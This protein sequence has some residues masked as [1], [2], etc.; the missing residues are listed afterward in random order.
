MTFTDMPTLGNI[1]TTL[2]PGEGF[3]IHGAIESENEYSSG[4]I[5]NDP[6]KRP[7][8]SSVLDGRNNEQWENVRRQRNEKL[9]DS[10]WTQVDDSVQDKSSWAIYRQALR[11][12][13]ENNADPF[14]ISWP[15]AP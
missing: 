5:Y 3:I 11:G 6:S 2:A 7:D 14:N 12:V 15:T 8:W 4:V 10:D 13:P 9:A 1:L